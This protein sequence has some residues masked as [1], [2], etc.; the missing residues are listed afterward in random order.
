MATALVYIHGFLS[1]PLSFKA[2]QTAAYIERKQLDI[3]TVTPSFSNLPGEAKLSL[4]ADISILRSTYRTIGLIGS[5]LGGFYASYLAEKFDLKAVL[6][7]PAVQPYDLLDRYPDVVENPYTHQR[8]SVDADFVAAI[9]AME[10]P[11]TPSR[12][13]LLTQ[14]ED[15]T[16]DYKK[17]VDWYAGCKQIVEQGGDHSFQ[18][19]ERHLPKIIKFLELTS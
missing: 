7:N 9:R 10:V 3:H 16:L 18:D 13:M 15:E 11:P 12:Y 5:S 2:Q 1:S 19:F 6:V 17:G 4:E 8:F 14:T